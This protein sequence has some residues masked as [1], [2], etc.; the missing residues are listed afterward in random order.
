MRYYRVIRNLATILH[1]SIS[2]RFTSAFTLK[3]KTNYL[4][5]NVD[6]TRIQ[7][8]N[9]DCEY[10][11]PLKLARTLTVSFSIVVGTIC[12][13]PF[14]GPV[15]RS[16]TIPPV[17]NAIVKGNAPPPIMKPLSKKTSCRN[18]EECQEMAER[19]TQEEADKMRAKITPPD[20]APRGTRY[21]NL[22]DD[23]NEEKSTE[24][25]KVITAKIGDTVTVYYKVLKL[26][27]RSYDGLSGEGTVVFSRGY[28]LE[29]DE[30]RAGEKLFTFK[31]G[32]SSVVDALNDAVPGMTI[33]GSRR[34]SILPEMGWRLPGTKCDGGPGGR[35]SGG[36][37]KTDY[38]VVPTAT[39]VAEES[40]F[41][42]SKQPFPSS[43]AE[44]RRMAQRFDQSLI[45]E[46][47]MINIKSSS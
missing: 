37:L 24:S 6:Q 17:A 12:C 47:K 26:G 7:A 1:F 2:S 13:S 33:G 4:N 39:I 38:V 28:G 22:D 8:G 21:R 30:G 5:L 46:V 34:I 27:K 23:E 19:A 14:G 45:M 16:L 44:Q 9:L 43:Y 42:K 31:L 10:D 36:E 40:C 32:D 15:M 20:V 3:P 29:D 11:E 35:G 25:S 18:V 41:D